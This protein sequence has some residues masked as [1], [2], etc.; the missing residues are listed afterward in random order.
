MPQMHPLHDMT[1]PD[2]ARIRA[3]QE[4][5]GRLGTNMDVQ[6]RSTQ[7]AQAVEQNA[8]AAPADAATGV[9]DVARARQ[10]QDG[11][12]LKALGDFAGAEALQAGTAEQRGLSAAHRTPGVGESALATLGA[13]PE[14]AQSYQLA[15]VQREADKA[16]APLADQQQLVPSQMPLA[17]G[18][19]MQD[20]AMNRATGR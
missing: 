16:G 9:I 15:R 6:M 13:H 5:P 20:L 3:M 1:S 7:L 11:H 17:S 12:V 14:I 19:A 8:G 18:Q 4:G 2:V 10:L